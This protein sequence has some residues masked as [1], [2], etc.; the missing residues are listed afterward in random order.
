LR[1]SDDRRAGHA[2][3]TRPAQRYSV[4]TR[5]TVIRDFEEEVRR[6]S[7]IIPGIPI[8]NSHMRR[9]SRRAACS[10]GW[11][12]SAPIRPTVADMSEPTAGRRGAA[13]LIEVKVAAIP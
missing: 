3:V 12:A 9:L 13:T 1:Y 4:G 7:K 10:T 8:S 2:S 6:I 5:R 11:K